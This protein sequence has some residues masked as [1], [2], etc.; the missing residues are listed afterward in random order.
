[1]VVVVSAA[2]GCATNPLT[3][4]RDF[5][6]LTVN[7]EIALGLEAAPQFVD[8]FGGPYG[9]PVIQAYVEEVGRKTA[10]QALAA[11]HPYQYSFTVVDSDVVNAFA[12]PGGPVCITRGLL[13][14]LSDESQLAGVLAHECTHVAAR[15]SAKQISRQMGAS[16]VLELVAAIAGGGESAGS[17]TYAADLAKLVAGLASLRYSRQMETEADNFGVDFMTRAGYQPLGMVGVMAMFEAKEQ[18]AGGGGPEFLRTHPYPENRIVNIRAAIDERHPAAPTN[19]QLRTG[20][21]TYQQ[22]VLARRGLVGT[23]SKST[24]K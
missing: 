9:D 12:L 15:H 1:M 22:K 21:D 19:A 7:Q 13:F 16:F 24:G 23:Y 4:K 6:L 14:E 10:A 20:R 18:E 2:T 3:G 11:S 17:S 5:M 8:E